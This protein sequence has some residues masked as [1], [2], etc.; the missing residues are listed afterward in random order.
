PTATRR[1]DPEPEPEDDEIPV[2]P[3]VFYTD[4][5]EKYHLRENCYGLRLATRVRDTLPCPR[6]MTPDFR[7]LLGSTVGGLYIGRNGHYHS[8]MMC[9]G[10]EGIGY[11]EYD[12]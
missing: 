8:V 9:A 12:T 7:R 5:G 4:R 1:R 2:E 6:C 10:R 11:D 3:S